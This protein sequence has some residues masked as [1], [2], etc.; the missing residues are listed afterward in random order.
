M[1][2]G[3]HDSKQTALHYLWRD[4][5]RILPAVYTVP[6]LFRVG[7]TLCAKVGALVHGADQRLSPPKAGESLDMRWR[8]LGTLLL[9]AS[10][11]RR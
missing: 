10:L 7:K 8:L 3:S 1:T 5:W 11:V 4:I 2:S 6:Y 9:A